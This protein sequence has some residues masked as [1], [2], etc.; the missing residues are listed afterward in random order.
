MDCR[1]NCRIA[2][3]REGAGWGGSLLMLKLY[4]IVSIYKKESWNKREIDIVQWEKL[5][6][7][8]SKI[9]Y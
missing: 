1:D 2:E 8:L 4:K 6:G 9:L 3:R 5:W 7:N